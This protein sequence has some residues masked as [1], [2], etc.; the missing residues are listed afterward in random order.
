VTAGN[1][2][3]DDHLLKRVRVSEKEARISDHDSLW[4]EFELDGT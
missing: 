1:F 2:V 3:R 4:A